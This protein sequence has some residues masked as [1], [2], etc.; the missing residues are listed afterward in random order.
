MPEILSYLLD[1]LGSCALSRVLLRIS[2]GLLLAPVD[3]DVTAFLLLPARRTRR[4]SM[5]VYH[6]D[7]RLVS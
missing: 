2:F 4:V 7:D 3:R 5:R 6:A 1:R